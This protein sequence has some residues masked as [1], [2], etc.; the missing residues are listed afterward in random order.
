MKLFYSLIIL[1]FF[2]NCSF[3]NKSG[4]WKS[5][6]KVSKNNSIFKEF[7][8]LSSS[9]EQYDKTVT[10][11]K[12]YQFNIPDPIINYK[13][14][15]IFYD[16][17]NNFKN[18]KYKNLNQLI[19]KSKKL[20]RHV[21]NKFVLFEN[22]NLIVS[23]IKGNIIIFSVSQNKVITKFNFYKKSYKKINKSINFIIEKNII[24][25][26]DNIGYLYAYNYKL[27]K[28]IW[29]KNYKTPF[30][31]NLKI[32]ENKIITSNQNN[33]L[34]FFNKANGDMLKS[35]PTEET[36][37]KNK[38]INNLSQTKD[39]S[40]YLNTYGSLYKIDNQNLSIKWFVNLNRSLDMNPSNLFLGNQTVIQNNIVVVNSNYNTY[41]IDLNTGSILHKTNFTSSIKPL[42]VNESLFLVTKNNLLICFDASSG[43][44]IYSYNINEKI[45]EFLN[46][47]KKEVE[48]KNLMLV[49]NKIFLFLQNSYILQ[50]NING[51]LE[52]I[53]KLPSKLNTHPIFIDNSIL[54]LDY[55]NKLSIVN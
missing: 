41:L 54:Y 2:Q 26:A 16:R 42:L 25:A 20:T 37:V 24:Y 15:D 34:L 31:S 36:L 39:S 11:N 40:L 28:I 9:I 33:N 53:N 55:K 21:V 29:A 35:I 10:L 1:I 49:N 32:F 8:T 38:F 18:Y 7:E 14:E 17:N 23:D 52:E 22:N 12:E 47:K 43:N 3:D 4:I 50:F 46:T 44:V 51:S 6:Q 30:R 19:F 27:N 48:V 45:A 13:W 5:E